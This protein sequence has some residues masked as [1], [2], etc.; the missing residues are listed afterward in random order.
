MIRKNNFFMIRIE[1]S[2][3][4]SY[5]YNN[6]IAV[7]QEV[8]GDM[9]LCWAIIFLFFMGKIWSNKCFYVYRNYATCNNCVG[10]LL[11]FYIG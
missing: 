5:V 8:V 2:N 9:Y 11:S 7:T 6:I 1:R 4:N 10:Q 3:S